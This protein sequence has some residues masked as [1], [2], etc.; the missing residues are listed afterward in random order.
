MGEL[1]AAINLQIIYYN[2][3]G[4]TGIR[5]DADQLAELGSIPGVD[6]LK[7]TSGDAVTLAEM[8]A[9]RGGEI[10]AFNGW[11]S[12]TFFGIASGAEASVWGLAS[13]LPDKAVELWHVLAEQKDLVRAR[14]LWVPLWEL[15]SFLESVNYVSGVKTA[16]EIIGESAGPT[17]RPIL[18][19]GEDERA[20]LTAILQRLDAV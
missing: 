13:I 4:C 18:A 5:L 10:K 2:V 19:L 7:D 17:R 14:E 8:L 9:V 15:S 11:D 6:Y 20:K 12:L 16:L 3:P 1:S